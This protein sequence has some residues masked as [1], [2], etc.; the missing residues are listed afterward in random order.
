MEC[1][2]NIG[3]KTISNLGLLAKVEDMAL[4]TL[5]YVEECGRHVSQRI[6]VNVCIQRWPCIK[7]VVESARVGEEHLIRDQHIKS[8]TVERAVF[9][10]PFWHLPVA[11]RHCLIPQSIWRRGCRR[12]GV[13]LP[14]RQQD[15]Y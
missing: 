14:A 10:E 3:G 7:R 13:C 12:Q 11:G 2:E 6:S 4:M 5:L 8:A 15:I 1:P 9:I